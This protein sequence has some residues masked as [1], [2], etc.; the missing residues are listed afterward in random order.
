MIQAIYRI[1]S[2]PVISRAVSHF[3]VVE[4]MIIDKICISNCISPYL[5]SI[6]CEYVWSGLE[7]INYDQQTAVS[8]IIEENHLKQMYFEIL[9]NLDEGIFL[10]DDN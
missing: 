4:K 3:F 6:R 8:K 10:Q 1:G 9:N 2:Y 7:N 5:R